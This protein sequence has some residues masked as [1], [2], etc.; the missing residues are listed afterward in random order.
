MMMRLPHCFA[1]ASAYLLPFLFVKVTVG[2]EGTIPGS[3]LRRNEREQHY[4]RHFSGDAIDSSSPAHHLNTTLCQ[5]YCKSGCVSYMTPLFE[6]YSPLQLFPNDSSWGEN[7]LL[8]ANVTFSAGDG[9][10][11]FTRSF[12][13]STDGTCGGVPE[14]QTLPLNECVG[15]FGAPRPWGTFELS[16]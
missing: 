5:D 1:R 12:F 3:F 9:L 11:T 6:C 10:I 14:S 4:S 8:D 13:L 15:P 2:K 16:S 7:D